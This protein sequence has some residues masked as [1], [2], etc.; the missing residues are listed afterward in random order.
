[1]KVVSRN[2]DSGRIPGFPTAG[3]SSGEDEREI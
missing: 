1:M 3:A 2:Y